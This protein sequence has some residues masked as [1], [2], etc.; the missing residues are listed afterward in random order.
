MG[1]SN[2]RVKIESM[3][4]AQ[5]V[6]ESEM[7]RKDV[8][9]QYDGV[10]KQFRE[11]INKVRYDEYDTINQIRVQT[12]GKQ[13]KDVYEEMKDEV[14]KID[15]EQ[16]R[17]RLDR[18]GFVTTTAKSDGDVSD[19]ELSQNEYY[20]ENDH[21]MVSA[22][23]TNYDSNKVKTRNSDRKSARKSLSRKNVDK[24]YN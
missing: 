11:V 10:R 4:K 12:A 16:A 3:T 8:K 24:K 13:D 17:T 19:G 6:D 20:K 5:L 7:Y 18:F 9:N 14:K 21:S 1:D 15:Q 22:N 23:N 2:D